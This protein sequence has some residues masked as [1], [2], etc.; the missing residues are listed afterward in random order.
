MTRT[1]LHQAADEVE[2]AS[3]TVTDEERSAR[4]KTLAE[5]LRSQAERDATPA[6]GAL[7]SVHEKLRELERQSDESAVTDTLQRAR[8]DILS[9]LETLED[10]GMKQHG[11]NGNAQ[12]NGSA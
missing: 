6:L 3:E 4:L 8:E 10:R 12:S 9:F 11:W 2:R 1:L 7:D 5:R